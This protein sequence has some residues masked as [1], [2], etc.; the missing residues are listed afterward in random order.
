MPTLLGP[1]GRA[2]RRPQQRMARNHI[3]HVHQWSGTLLRPDQIGLDTYEKMVDTD[4]TIGAA[5]DFLALSVCAKLG[6]YTHPKRK[7]QKFIRECF[8]RMRGSL[9]MAVEEMLAAMWAGFSGTEICLKSEGGQ[10]MLDQ[11]V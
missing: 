1:D 5:I 10:W 4:E 7:F 6:E 3:E 11:L 8:G 2:L 9:A